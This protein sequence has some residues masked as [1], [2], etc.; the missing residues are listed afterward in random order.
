M[1][2]TPFEKYSGPVVFLE[3]NNS[4]KLGHEEMDIL[5]T[6]G[7]SPGSISFY[8]KAGN[9]IIGGD[10][11]FNGSIGRTDLPGG[12]MDTLVASIRKQFYTLPDDTLVYSGH[13][14]ETTIGFEK[15]NNPFV[16]EN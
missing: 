7:H 4:I 15:K 5:F 10:V 11:L 8:H 3:E 1:Y 16:R 9:F 14:P 13:G 6:P 2:Q 12:D